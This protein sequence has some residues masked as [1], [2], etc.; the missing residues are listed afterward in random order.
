M[1]DTEGNRDQQ[2]DLMPEGGVTAQGADYKEFR[3]AVAKA[4]EGFDEKKE[5]NEES[6]FTTTE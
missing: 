3:T 5:V 4:V 1:V 6:E 2:L